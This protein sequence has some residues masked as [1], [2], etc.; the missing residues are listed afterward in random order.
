MKKNN[1][2]TDYFF[3]LIGLMSLLLSLVMSVLKVASEISLKWVWVL[4]PIFM[5]ILLV[6]ICFF[7]GV[8]YLA[9]G[10]SYHLDF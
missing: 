8:S 4:S 9:R 6:F 1:K 5:F 2:V 7:M 10:A 3:Y